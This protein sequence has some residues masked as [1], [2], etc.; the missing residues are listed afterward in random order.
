MTSP[1]FFGEN[2][3]LLNLF[4]EWLESRD[5]KLHIIFGREGAI[6]SATAVAVSYTWSWDPTCKIEVAELWVFL[7]I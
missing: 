3:N 2:M 4:G 5:L 6:D 1:I 7:K